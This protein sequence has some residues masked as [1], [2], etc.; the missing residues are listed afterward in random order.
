MKK[1]NRP[2]GEMPEVYQQQIA[3]DEELHN[4]NLNTTNED[5]VKDVPNSKVLSYDLKKL[6]SFRVLR[7]Q[8]KA[9]NQLSIFL[10]DM[11][12]VLNEFVPK[13][14]QLDLD[15]LVHVLNIAEQYFIYGNKE[16]REK[17]KQYAVKKLMTTYFRNDEEVLEKMIGSVW[18]KVHKSNMFKRLCKRISNKVFFF[19]RTRQ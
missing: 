18:S 10:F 8:Y 3:K 9:K 5:V 19:L 17:A 7:K 11:E 14:N 16:E 15:L 1:V 4:V 13:D 12:K 6:K 2:S